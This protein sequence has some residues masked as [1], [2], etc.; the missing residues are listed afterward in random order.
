ML[1]YADVCWQTIDNP[2][3]DTSSTLVRVPTERL[4]AT[5]SILPERPGG[6]TTVM[7]GRFALFGRLIPFGGQ[8]CV[9]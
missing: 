6:A 9:K 7:H 4:A 3:P 2:R 5:I 8:V 1:T